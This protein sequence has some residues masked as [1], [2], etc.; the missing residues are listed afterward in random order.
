MNSKVIKFTRLPDIDF[1][2]RGKV[3]EIYD[4]G[5]KFLMIATDR[6]SCFDVVLPTP[7][8][9][10]GK[11][12]TKL[13]AFWFEFTKDIIPNHFLTTRIEEFPERLQKYKEVL[14]GRSMLVRKVRP[15]PIECVVRGYLS[16]SAWREYK[17]TQ[18]ICGV[19]L[20]AGLK[21]S[22]KLP[23]PI[24][25]PAT[26]EESGHDVNVTQEYIEKVVGK[27]V[28]TTLKEVSISLYKRACLYAESKGII[29]ADTKF[30][31]GFLNGDIILIDE[32]LT[33]D[34]SR[35]WPK[36]AYL[37]GKP[38][39]SFDKQFVRDYLESLGWDKK[40]PAPNLPEEIVNQTTQRYLQALT[41]LTGES[42][43]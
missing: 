38:Q 41:M 9:Y 24:F 15:I 2:K 27:K 19:K 39:P 18:S 13:S 35:F 7:I 17:K 3:R 31:F 30:E 11:V 25:T 4:L 5:D 37:P 12:L 42:L 16:G 43:G 33:P 14:V 36:E 29:I 21:E 1:F 40:P 20:P 34:S 26:K 28:A 6:I 10:K 32:V 22:D 23:Y 8:P